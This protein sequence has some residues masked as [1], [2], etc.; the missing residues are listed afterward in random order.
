MQSF[1]FYFSIWSWRKLTLPA[2][3]WQVRRGRGGG[4]KKQT[5]NQNQQMNLSGWFYCAD[6]ANMPEGK[7]SQ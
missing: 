1:F 3:G 6:I 2:T 5:K 4:E 7:I